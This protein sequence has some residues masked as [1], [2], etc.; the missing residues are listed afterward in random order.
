[1]KSLLILAIFLCV[2]AGCTTKLNLPIHI[3]KR[4]QSPIIHR[5]CSVSI[6]TEFFP[7]NVLYPSYNV[8]SNI[9]QY[10]ALLLRWWNLSVLSF[11]YSWLV[12]E[13]R[14]VSFI[15]WYFWFQVLAY[16]D[17]WTHIRMVI[18]GHMCALLCDIMKAPVKSFITFS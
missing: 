1:M 9:L 18:L 5:S 12:S 8:A 15:Y 6:V 7:K 4:I 14:E 11:N 10:I 2:D 13:H 17:S 16:V 3:S